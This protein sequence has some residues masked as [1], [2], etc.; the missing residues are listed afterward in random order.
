MQVGKVLLFNVGSDLLRPFLVV[1]IAEDGTASGE[2]FLDYLQDR[3][4]EWVQK[5]CFTAP[6]EQHRTIWVKSAKEGLAMGEV[7]KAPKVPV[8]RRPSV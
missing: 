1:A 2:L 3:R 5:H 7:R 4:V 6:W 8:A